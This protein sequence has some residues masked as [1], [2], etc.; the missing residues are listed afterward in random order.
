M[1]WGELIVFVDVGERK[2]PGEGGVKPGGTRRVAYLREI[3]GPRDDVTPGVQDYRLFADRPVLH[4]GGQSI[5]HHL[6]IEAG[7]LLQGAD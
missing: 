5:E 4:E 1:K 6:G 2:L 3:V 7:G